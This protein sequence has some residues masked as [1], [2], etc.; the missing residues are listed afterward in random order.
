[1]K[2]YSPV[3]SSFFRQ[4]TSPSGN[5]NPRAAINNSIWIRR[6]VIRTSMGIMATSVR[7]CS[8]NPLLSSGIIT[9][10]RPSRDYSREDENEVL[11]SG[12]ADLVAY[13]RFFLANPDLPRRFELDAHLVKYIN[14][15][16]Y[17]GSYKKGNKPLTT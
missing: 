14:E 8:A 4:N 5:A 10:S 13:G 6:S 17:G 16:F 12:Y 3:S 7:V 9:G 11:A 1:M 2:S 15:T